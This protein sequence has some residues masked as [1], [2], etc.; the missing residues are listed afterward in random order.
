MDKKETRL[1]INE[2][3]GRPF[4]VYGLYWPGGN[5]FYVGKGQK[6]RVFQ[7][8]NHSHNPQVAN[9]FKALKSKKLKPEYEI[10]EFY[11]SETA[12]LQGETRLQKKYMPYGHLA[13]KMVGTQPTYSDD[14]RAKYKLIGDCDDLLLE[15]E[16]ETS[17][18]PKESESLK[19]WEWFYD[20][21]INTVSKSEVAESEP[22]EKESFRVPRYS[23][24][25][26]LPRPS[27]GAW[28]YENCRFENNKW[29]Q[30]YPNGTA[31]FTKPVYFS[32]MNN[33][34]KQ[35]SEDGIVSYVWFDPK[36]D[37]VTKTRTIT[38]NR[39]EWV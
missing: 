9:S 18:R 37:T 2:N 27:R 24:G 34:R 21:L 32:P 31:V 19:R 6:G 4:Y 1:L 30:C 3:A 7:H 29:E 26:G 36:K 33:E 25:E 23:V 8:E 15:H 12:A 10:F 5:C 22:D 28:H 35:A 11:T 13:N 17:L 14:S 39:G 16:I 20:F 38:K